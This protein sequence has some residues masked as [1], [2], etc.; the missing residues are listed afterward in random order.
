LVSILF[1][2]RRKRRKMEYAKTPRHN[3]PR[4]NMVMPMSEEV[5][6]RLGDIPV[7]KW[8]E[9]SKKNTNN[10]TEISENN[11]KQKV[12]IN[13][14]PLHQPLP[15]IS[16]YDGED[17]LPGK[18][19]EKEREGKSPREKAKSARS[20]RS[21]KSKEEEKEREKAKEREGKSPRSPRSPK[22]ITATIKTNS[23]SSLISTD[24]VCYLTYF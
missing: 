20:P 22:R 10:D 23:L 24:V 11:T 1:F 13:L 15:S 7:N 6:R 5:K 19:E 18:I 8:M 21:P 14:A 12:Q 2:G 16:D 9:T 17:Y 3:K 4:H